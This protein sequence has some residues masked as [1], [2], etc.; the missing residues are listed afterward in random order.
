MNSSCVFGFKKDLKF[1]EIYEKFSSFRSKTRVWYQI[2]YALQRGPSMIRECLSGHRWS[3]ELGVLTSAG[4]AR[5]FEGE[6]HVHSLR[7]SAIYRRSHPSYSTLPLLP[8]LVKIVLCSHLN[9]WC[10]YT[11]RRRSSCVCQWTEF[12][13]VEQMLMLFC[14]FFK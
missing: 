6:D 13:W 2:R 10:G 8:K 14:S 3:N 5:S 1:T 12:F 7:L 11:P 4:S 9:V